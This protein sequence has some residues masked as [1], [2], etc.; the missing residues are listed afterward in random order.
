MCIGNKIG[1]LLMQL[2]EQHYFTIQVC[3]HWVQE[4]SQVSSSQSQLCKA[5]FYAGDRL[6][7]QLAFYIFVSRD[8]WSGVHIFRIQQ[9]TES[10]IV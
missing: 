9:G 2:L 6:Q 4:H 1:I 10:K 8:I 7:C 3:K 5:L